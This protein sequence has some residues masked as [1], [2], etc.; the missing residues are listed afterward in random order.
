MIPN[1][2][3]IHIPF[4]NRTILEEFDSMVKSLVQSWI[5]EEEA[6]TKIIALQK[7][8]YKKLDN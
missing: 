5:E 7:L 6:K 3:K 2:S 1:N 4:I 8:K